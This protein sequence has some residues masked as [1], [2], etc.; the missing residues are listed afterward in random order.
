MA[1]KKME[2]K[3]F[4]TALKIA[5]KAQQLYPELENVSRMIVVC[6]VHISGEKKTHGTKKD[7]H[8]ILKVEPSVDEATI[9]N[10]YIL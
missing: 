3:D 6:E 1:E 4:S 9:K 10:K 5:V 2:N 8:G 7:W